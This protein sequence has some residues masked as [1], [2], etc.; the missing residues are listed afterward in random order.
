MS[1]KSTPLVSTA[2]TAARTGAGPRLPRS[3]AGTGGVRGD[4]WRRVLR[5]HRTEMCACGRRLSPAFAGAVVRRRTGVHV[6]LP[7]HDGGFGGGGR[8][9]SCGPPSRQGAGR[10]S[11]FRASSR[12]HA[13][14]GAGGRI[15]AARLARLIARA[16]RQTHLARRFPPGRFSRPQPSLSAETPKGGPGSRL[17]LLS[18]Y[19]MPPNVKPIWEQKMKSPELFH[20][21]PVKTKR[22]PARRPQ[23]RVP[24]LL[25]LGRVFSGLEPGRAAALGGTS[26]CRLAA[27]P[28]L[29]ARR[30]CRP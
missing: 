13:C 3:G 22:R 5:S 30:R 4:G 8:L 21:I 16:R 14:A 18:F 1:P 23:V 10:V 6:L 29:D 19:T 17:S 9:R 26:A 27:P 24:A 12:G 20:E 11:L 25:P 15:A 28:C 2:E 7:V